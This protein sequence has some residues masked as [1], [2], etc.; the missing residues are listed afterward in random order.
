[1]AI[2]RYALVMRHNPILKDF[3][4]SSPLSVGNGE[5]AFTVDATGMQTYP[6]RYSDK[7]PLCTQS[8]W[9]WH[10][11]P[12]SS[13]KDSY[14]YKEL[15]PELYDTYGRKVGYFT[16][17]K[18][19][20][21]IF[22]WLRQNPHRLNLGQIGLEMTMDDGM[23][24][25]M[26]N[27][28]D[29]YQ[30]LNMWE[31][32][33][34][35]DF[36]ARKKAVSVKTCCH[37]DAD[38]LAFSIE[39]ELVREG[40]LNLHLKFPYASPEKTASNWYEDERHS[41]DIIGLSSNR[42]DL[43]R[44]FEH[45]HYFVSIMFTGEGQIERTGRNAL[46]LKPETGQD[47]FQLICSFSQNPVRG[48]LP[49]FED[50]V[51]ASKARWKNF[52]SNGGTVQ[53]AE[54]KDIRAIELERRIVLSQYLTAIQCA[55][56]LPPPPPETGLTCN[57][58]Y[59]KFHLEMHWWHAAHFCL[60][61][62]AHLLEKSLWWYKKILPRARRLASLQGYRGAR[63]PKMVGSEGVDSPSNI[64]PL[65]IWQ[66][67]HPI[68]YAELCYR[69]R[70]NKDTLTTYKDIVFETA[71]FMA[72]FVVWDTENNRYVLGPP[73]I[74]AQE[75]HEPEITINPT[76]ELEYWCFGLNLAN[77]WRERLGFEI[78]TNWKDVAN[79]LAS[80]PE[81]EG[82]Y[83]AHE[84]CPDTYTGFN[85]DHPSMLGAFGML[86]GKKVNT[87]I[88]SNTLDKV[89]ERWKLEET[90]GWDFPMMAMTAA[91]LGRPELA[92]E[93]LLMDSPKNGYLPNGHNRQGMRCDLPL[94]LP[95]NGGLLFAVAMMAAG[96]D[97]CKDKDAPGFPKN[98]EWQVEWEELHPIP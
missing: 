15:E 67:P 89:L 41:T 52:W 36:S 34:Y 86:P 74:P 49:S 20:E 65:L 70:P 25:D 13:E 29:I 76:F 33:I 88:M 61:N 79:N 7:M 3:N 2:D 11:T 66:Q 78:N 42:I 57:S 43:L 60:W 62:R 53:L 94:Y 32:L 85:F 54:S 10:T 92:I 71:E 95:G 48:R 75:N 56:S 9:G 35:S 40:H 77:L 97:D 81:K 31:G 28:S 72:S 24:V 98:G 19:Q 22:H 23:K 8:Q 14:S 80:L 55:G 63:W 83:L 47:N 84:N 87:A 5:F 91:R 18:G 37:P 58:W 4:T 59:G 46:I 73:T 38:I 69:V 44:L 68:S 39:S 96:W 93:I 12:V 1:M 27:I 45:D 50:T 16:D 21:E 64:G 90:W 30:T 6:A 26:D 17:S 82:V 51:R